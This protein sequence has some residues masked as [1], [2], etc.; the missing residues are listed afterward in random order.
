MTRVLTALILIPLAIGLIFLGPPLAVRAALAAVALLCLH[1]CFSIV[2]A[3][4]VK[5][6]RPVGYAAG[7]VMV[8]TSE[9]LGPLLVVVT[10]ALMA[11]TLQIERHKLAIPVVAFTVFAIAYTCGPFALARALHELNP[12]WMFVVLVV[13]WVGDSAAL[14]VG[15]SIGKNKLAPSISPNK[16]WE[17]TIASLAL[18]AGAGLAYLLY[19]DVST[20]HWALLAGATAFINI[21]GQTGDLAESVLKRGADLKDSG[22]LLPGH[23]GMLDRMD[24]ALFS[25]PALYLVLEALRRLS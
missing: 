16:T 14:Y 19:F 8:L 24:G 22:A 6:F 2:E 1:E 3:M 13:N 12:H 9:P 7:A 23:G 21:A 5:P 4:G 25:Y 18:G 20:L 10:V 11:L 15:R 17:G